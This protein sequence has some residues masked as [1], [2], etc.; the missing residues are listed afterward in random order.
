[1]LGMWNMVLTLVQQGKSARGGFGYV[2]PVSGFVCVL[3][4]CWFSNF[5]VGSSERWA[6]LTLGWTMTRGE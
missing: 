1:M 2:S 4:C 6:F 3:T 5:D